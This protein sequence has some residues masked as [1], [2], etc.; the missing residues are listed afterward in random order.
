M[1]NKSKIVSHGWTENDM[2]YLTSL[3][4]HIWASRTKTAKRASWLVK[5][6]IKDTITIVHQVSVSL[7]ACACLCVVVRGCAFVCAFVCVCVCVCVRAC[8]CVHICICASVCDEHVCAC[9]FIY[10]CLCNI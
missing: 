5:C 9:M 8:L 2:T 3:H 6:I 7:H 10:V 4:V 1:K